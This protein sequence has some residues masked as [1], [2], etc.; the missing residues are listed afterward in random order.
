MTKNEDRRVRMTK[1]ILAESLLELMKEK[2]ISKITASELCRK[3]DINRNTF[4]AHYNYPEQVLEDIENQVFNKLKTS[5]ENS[6]KNGDISSLLDEICHEIKNNATLCTILLSSQSENNVLSRLISVAHD[7][8][9]EEWQ[10]L[11]TNIKRDELES[12]FTFATAGS[13]GVIREWM[14]NGLIESPEIIANRL[15]KING[16]IPL[17]LVKKK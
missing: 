10:E 6:V 8:T 9:I 2:P 13:M 15:K 17:G 11:G 5:I 16:Y 14:N 1:M 12:Y 3:A 4:Y 7:R